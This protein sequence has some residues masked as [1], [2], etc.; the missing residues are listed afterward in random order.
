MVSGYLNNGDISGAITFVQNAF[1]EYTILPSYDTHLKILELALGT[2]NVYEAKRHVYFIQQLWRF[3][4]NKYHCRKLTRKISETVSNPLLSKKSLKKLFHY[5]G[6]RLEEEDFFHE[7]RE[8][9]A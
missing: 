6:F 5:F 2:E 8:N 4:P 9:K 1:N 3:R 7:F